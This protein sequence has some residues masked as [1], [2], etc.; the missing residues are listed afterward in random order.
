MSNAQQVDRYRLI[1]K[2]TCK[3]DT[4]TW[5][6]RLCHCIGDVLKWH[7]MFVLMLRRCIE[8]AHDLVLLLMRQ[9]HLTHDDCVNA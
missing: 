8:V 7:M 6:R 4:E 3:M 9:K 1:T 2:Y 5:L